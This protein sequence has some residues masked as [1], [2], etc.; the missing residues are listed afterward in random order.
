MYFKWLHLYHDDTN[1]SIP[2]KKTTYNTILQLM[3]IVIYP[4]YTTVNP[5]S[6]QSRPTSIE[7]AH[8]IKLFNFYL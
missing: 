3:Q 5:L 7:M 1:K 8:K 4:Q 6:K 2:L